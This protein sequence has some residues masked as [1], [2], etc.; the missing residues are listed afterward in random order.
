MHDACDVF[1]DGLL[2]V[3]IHVVFMSA[4]I[5]VCYA[6]GLLEPRF[7][8]ACCGSRLPPLVHGLGHVWLTYLREL[9][10]CDCFFVMPY[11]VLVIYNCSI[12]LYCI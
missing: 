8:I 9:V 1:P 5:F 4:L 11:Y 2:F 7:C 12:S 3:A 6:V 10:Y